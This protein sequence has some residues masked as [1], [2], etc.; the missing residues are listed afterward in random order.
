MVVELIMYKGLNHLA[1]TIDVEPS[2]LID[3]CNT[4]C[5]ATT[6]STGTGVV[7]VRPGLETD[8]VKMYVPT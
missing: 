2:I 1:Y 3:N 7:A 5:G 8:K 6:T 4:G